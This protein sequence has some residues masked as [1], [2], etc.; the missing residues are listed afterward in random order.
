[1]RPLGR[2]VVVVGTDRGMEIR[3]GDNRMEVLEQGEEDRYK[4]T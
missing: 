1:M 4:D 2:L 3:K